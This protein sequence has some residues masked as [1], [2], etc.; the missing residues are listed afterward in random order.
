MTTPRHITVGDVSIGNDLPFVLIAG[1]CQMESR[2]HAMQTA[3]T[4]KEITDKLGIGLIYKTS[5]DKAN[6]TSVDTPRG[7]GIDQALPIFADIKAEFGVP[8]LTDVHDA[9]QCAAVAEVVDVLQ[10]PAFLCRQTDLLLAAG[11]TGRVLNV[12]KGQFLAPWDMANVVKKI[13][14]TG[15]DQILLC[16]RGASFGYN[17]LVSDMRSLPIMAQ[18]G[19]PI[20]FDATHSVQQ[21]G[22]Q[23]STSGGQREFAPVLARAALAIG[24]AAVF[25]ETHE[26]PDNAPSDGPNMIY[27][28]QLPEIL[29]VLVQIDNVAKSSPLRI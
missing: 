12:K 23:G 28:N 20:V 3:G 27:L 6:R 18:T 25:M 10:I 24:V 16:E 13:E 14:S 26:D 5:F 2:G 9:G 15:N 8:T 7:L 4:L 22:G 29:D 1:P 21:P 19:C 17:T 11:K